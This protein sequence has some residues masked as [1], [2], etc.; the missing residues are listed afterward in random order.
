M[1]HAPSL[2]IAFVLFLSLLLTLEAGYRLGRRQANST[3]AASKEH[4]NGIQS[5]M[6]GI[7]ALLLGFTFSLALQRYDARSE[8]VV[9]E[10]NAIGTTWL[11]TQLLPP[12]AQGPMQ[13]A[14]R[15]YVALRLAEGQTH[16][17]DS[18]TRGPLI[19]RTAQMQSQ[20][21]DLARR[22]VQ[23][24]PGPVT[25]GLFVQALNESID[26]FGSREA[27]LQRHVPGEVLALLYLTFLLCGGIVGYAAG[28]GG[29]RPSR[30]SIVL[31]LL[32]VVLVFLILDL[33]HPRSG[34]V[35]VSQ[36]PLLDLQAT[37]AAPAR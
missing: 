4:I 7:L 8:A 5:A 2:L 1:H 10:A 33:D 11:R 30:V 34:W 22:A 16:L 36:Q 14:L 26:A 24:D 32:I 20:L 18:E 15:D 9:T 35:Q 17:G 25:T 19:E 23:A 37:M 13:S 29:H 6:L 31:V 28:I 3:S 12:A 21:W 27:A